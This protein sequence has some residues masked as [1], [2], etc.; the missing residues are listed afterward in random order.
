[1]I[2]VEVDTIKELHIKLYISA[3][4][5]EETIAFYSAMGADITDAPITSIAEEEP[6][7]LQMV[8]VV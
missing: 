2:I 7:D 1:M 3:C 8:Y 4:P 5:A 6:D